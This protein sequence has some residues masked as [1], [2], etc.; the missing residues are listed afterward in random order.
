MSE[1]VERVGVD[2]DERYPTYC[3]TK[4]HAEAFIEVPV[5]TA[6]R[7]RAAEA[8]F[9]AAQDEI[10]ELFDEALKR[11]QKADTIAK[12]ERQVAEAQARLEA[13]KNS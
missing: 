5:E 8:A 9:D 1:P 3:L 13:V 6:A 10:A 12:A 4:K 7:W 11:K 2:R